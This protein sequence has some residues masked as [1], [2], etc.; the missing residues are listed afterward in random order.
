MQAEGI[1]DHIPTLLFIQTAREW[2]HEIFNLSLRDDGEIVRWDGCAADRW[3]SKGGD[4]H[5]ELQPLKSITPAFISVAG[6]AFL[7]INGR[8]DL[9]RRGL[10]RE[11][12]TQRRRRR[13]RFIIWRRCDIGGERKIAR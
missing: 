12:R 10:S 1:G 11:E 9:Q 6:S 3:Q 8:T 4:L 7:R 5:T 13:G 2:R